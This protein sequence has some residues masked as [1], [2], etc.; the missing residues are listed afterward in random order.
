MVPSQASLRL[1]DSALVYNSAALTGGAVYV[2]ASSSDDIGSRDIQPHTGSNSLEELDMYNTTLEGN[3]A[4]VGG[5]V[6]LAES[7]GRLAAFQCRIQQN[8]ADTFAFIVNGLPHGGAVWLGGSLVNLE[9]SGGTVVQGNEAAEGARGNFVYALGNVTSVELHGAGLLQNGPDPAWS[10]WSAVYV[11]G[12]VDRVLVCDSVVSENVGGVLVAEW[13]ISSIIVDNSSVTGNL[14]SA[15]VSGTFVREVVV[16][17]RSTV[18]HNVAYGM[19]AYGAFLSASRIDRLVITNGCSVENNTA[20]DVPGTG[21]AVYALLRIGYLEVSGGSSFSHNRARGNGG[22]VAARSIGSVV[23]TDGAA[24]SGNVAGETYVP[25]FPSFAVVH[26]HF[27]YVEANGG[28]FYAQ[29]TIDGLVLSDG[30]RVEGNQASQDGGAVFARLVS[31]LELRS[32]ILRNNTARLGGGGA[33]ASDALSSEVSLSL[34]HGWG[35]PALR[36]QH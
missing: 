23:V 13:Q 33:I 4:Y 34:R 35:L 30:A 15:F 19:Y 26:Q 7:A 18:A 3:S 17:N 10:G 9:L 29:F 14:M 11:H 24:V 20:L 32:A 8:Y 25:A 31:G 6:S 36:F 5:A 21:G 1:V 22:A 16:T 12:G 28:A 27:P 2:G